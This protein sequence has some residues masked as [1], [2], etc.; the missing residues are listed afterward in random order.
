MSGFNGFYSQPQ[1]EVLD[2]L[3]EDPAQRQRILDDVF[4]HYR[5][6]PGPQQMVVE[7][8]S[9]LYLQRSRLARC[10]NAKMGQ[11]VRALEI[12]REVL[13]LQINGD[14]ADVT[15]ED[16]LENGLRN[17]RDCP[18]K[19][20]MI[21]D[22]VKALIQ[23]AENCNYSDAMPYLTTIYGKQAS[24]RGAAII[25]QF[26][27]LMRL[28]QEREEALK[29]RRPWPPPGDPVFNEEDAPTENDEPGYDPRLDQ[30][31]QLLLRDLT[32][33]LH[34]V[35]KLYDIY[36]REE[37]TLT[38]MKRDAALELAPPG[39]YDL[40][41]QIWLVDR[42]MDAKIRLFMKMRVEDRNWEQ[43][44]GDRGRTGNRE[45][46]TGNSYGEPVT[47]SG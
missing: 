4:N 16:V 1:P 39:G 3:R 32:R 22:K 17:I 31:S 18:G 37:V 12:Q 40:A 5:P 26:I 9:D 28:S 6:Q 47:R 44:I 24:L 10:Q 45:Q 46:V 35:T 20:E 7:N 33:E 13:H 29:H 42:N 41:R 43:G 11:N 23:Q 36:V 34:D 8:I 14:V 27:D 15:Q 30:P 25:N 19:F 38:Q 21:L 2:I